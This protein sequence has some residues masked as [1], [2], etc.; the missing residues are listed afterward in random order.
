M[1]HTLTEVIINKLKLLD[2]ELIN[3][4]LKLKVLRGEIKESKSRCIY[5]QM[6]ILFVNVIN[7]MLMLMLCMLYYV[8]VMPCCYAVLLCY[9]NDLLC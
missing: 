5:N 1:F 9:V 4:N 8:N 2:L 3:V 7:I 6:K